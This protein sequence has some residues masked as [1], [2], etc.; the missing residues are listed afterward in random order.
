MKKPTDVG[1]NRTGIQ[2]SAAEA[3]RMLEG[4][5]QG[6]PKASTDV[7]RLSEMRLDYSRKAE[8]LG[9]M[10]PP[11]KTEK[12]GKGETPAI[13]FDL[14][15]E[16]QAFERSGVRLYE[17]LIT[18]LEAASVHRGEPVREDLEHLRDDEL[19]HFALLGRTLEQLGADPF[20]VTPSADVTGVAGSGVL[21]VLADP[22]TTLT[23]GLQAI[24]IAELV[25]TG[26]WQ[27]LVE[28]ADKLGHDELREEFHR[29][30]EEEHDHLARVQSWLAAAVS[31]QAGIAPTPKRPHA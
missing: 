22:R 10:P 21:Q 7:A 27:S 29:A 3:K 28:L 4:A 23:Q 31:G 1:G 13:F 18:K 5:N 30:L 8:P 9:T 20:A 24:R 19:R 6:V 15:G 17:L 25:D 12:K 2:V 26:S 14:L 16:R 11:V